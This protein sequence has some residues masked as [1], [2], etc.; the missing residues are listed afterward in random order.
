MSIQD[1]VPTG[2]GHNS[3]G[4]DFPQHIPSR[5]LAIMRECGARYRVPMRVLLSPARDRRASAARHEAMRRVR[6]EIRYHGKPPSYPRMGRWFDR[7]H[8]TV[9]AAIRRDPSLEFA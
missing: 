1:I 7:D 5:V 9:I 2:I 4:A 3:G 6:H 8:S